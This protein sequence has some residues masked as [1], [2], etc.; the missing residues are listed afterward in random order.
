MRREFVDL[1]QHQ[2]GGAYEFLINPRNAKTINSIM[3]KNYTKDLKDFAKVID[4]MDGIDTKKLGATLQKTEIDPLSQVVP[5]VDIKYASSQYRDRISSITMKVTRII[6]KMVDF[7]NKKQMDKAVFELLT[8]VDGMKKVS[9]AVA[10]MDFK[11]K[12]PADVRKI[13]GLISE[14]LPV[15]MY[16]S[17]KTAVSHK[18]EEIEQK[19][20]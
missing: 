17:V 5:G 8:D 4:A 16:S 20:Q 14:I 13:V 12:N 2:P 10:N 9:E 3:G 6:S 7:R 18:A 11:I 15:Y 1:L 19:I